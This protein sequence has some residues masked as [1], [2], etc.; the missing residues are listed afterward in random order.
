M[1]LMMDNLILATWQT[2]AGCNTPVMQAAAQSFARLDQLAYW[3]YQLATV[4]DQAAFDHV[5]ACVA[6]GLSALV[7]ADKLSERYAPAVLRAVMYEIQMPCTARP[8]SGRQRA[9][10]ACIA[11][12]SWSRHALCRHVDAVLKQL[13]AALDRADRLTR[14]QTIEAITQ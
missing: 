12:K 10:A 13:D 11:Q 9:A 8:F 1:G 4:G 3:S 7:A 2:A 6:S 14:D 5:A